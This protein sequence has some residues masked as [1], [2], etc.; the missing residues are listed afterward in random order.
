MKK[1]NV[2]V[3]IMSVAIVAGGLLLQQCSPATQTLENKPNEFVGDLKCQS[4]HSAEFNDWK[5]S[6]HYHAMLPASDSTV[7]GDFNNATYSADGITS[8]F[9]KR[10]G[11]FIINT[12]GEDGKNH[13]FEVKYTF[14]YQPLQ[15]YLVAFPGGRM[16][17]TRVCWDVNKKQWFHQYQGQ[18]IAPNEWIHWTGNGQNWNT[19]CAYCHST[20]LQ[21]NYDL[22][23]D[24]YHTTFK[25]V[26]V[27]CESCHGAGK[28]HIDYVNSNNFKEGKKV[29]NSFLVMGSNPSQLTEI[30]SCAPCHAVRMEVGKNLI[31]SNE[32]LDNFIPEIPT[33]E[34]F[35]AD[36]QVKLED[37][38]HTS[39][40][41]SKMYRHNVK[42][43][44]CHNPHTGRVLF[45]TNN[46]CLQC[47]GKSYDDPK[48]TF[49]ATNTVATQCISCHMP[50]RTFMEVDERHDHSFRVPRPDLSVKYNTPNACN[51]C[52]KDKSM[53]WSAD[54]VN[55]WYGP[56]RKYHFA[57]DLV[58]GSLLN[59]DSEGHLLKLMGD[60]SIPSIIKATAAFYLG[61]INSQNSITALIQSLDD[62]NAQVRYR[63]LRGLTNFPVSSFMQNVLPLL[64]DKVRAVRVA[65]ADLLLAIPQQEF[66]AQFM[67]AFAAARSELYNYLI[68][69]A[70]F[71]VGSSMLADYYVHTGDNANA[72]KF[73]LRSIQ[74]DSML[75]YA[76]LNLASVYN[77]EM[78]NEAALFQLKQAEKI[79]P[80]SDRIN[81]N[82]ALLQIEMKDTA[83]ALIHFR[84]AVALQSTDP[85]LYYNYGLL[86]MQVKKLNEAENCFKAGLK[87]APMN[88]DLH[89]ALAYYYLTGKNPQKAL[90]YARFLKQNAP[91]NPQYQSIF[92]ALKI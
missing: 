85:R 63:A 45:T 58:P 18:K 55:K 26:N 48:H 53:Q 23:S 84:K 4:C 24:S 37:F 3:V 41:Q 81:Y 50:A 78:Q 12:R 46:L 87:I 71:A 43:S 34:R 72:I 59:K 27:S 17:A 62:A 21:K 90:P 57:E 73:Y 49:H 64:S 56:E 10:D 77:S 89:Y 74:K 35:F 91:N 51:D 14:G 47:H 80:N 83:Q 69:Q 19:M 67:D 40:L 52:H 70:D 32:L 5:V 31:P 86:L 44:N 6:D 38:I 33:D 1:I 88:L 7:V 25:T 11:K 16:Q 8:T 66:P 22:E 54:A 13:D 42:C 28:N 65:A 60:T 20:D 75:N 9:F 2:L 15:Q 68:N 30:N 39:F 79:N 92:S 82:L 76:R 36:G 61:N 29:V